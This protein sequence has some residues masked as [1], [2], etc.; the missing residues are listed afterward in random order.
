MKLKNLPILFALV[1]PAIAQQAAVV[2]VDDAPG[3]YT[4]TMPAEPAWRAYV[5]GQSVVRMTVQV[6]AGAAACKLGFTWMGLGEKEAMYIHAAGEVAHGPYVGYGPLNRPDFDSQWLPGNEFAVTA[7]GKPT[8]DFPFVLRSVSCK[9]AEELAAEPVKLSRSYTPSKGPAAGDQVTAMVDDTMVIAE[10]R[11]GKVM[12]QDDIILP[13]DMPV[14]GK[15]PNREAMQAAAN[16]AWPKFRVPYAIAMPEW[17]GEFPNFRINDV[18]RGIA[19]WNSLFPGLLVEATSADKD[20]VKI[21]TANGVC[22]SSVGRVGGAQT[23]GLAD[24]CSDA[25]ILHEFAHAIGMWHEQSRQDRDEYVKINWNKIRDGKAHNFAMV[26]ISNGTDYG[27]YDYTSLM[28]Y[29]ATAFSTDGSATIERL[30]PMP[31]GGATMGGATA[32]S[33]GDISAVRN[34]IC[35]VWYNAPAAMTLDG[36]G[37]EVAVNIVLPNYCAWTVTETA[38]WLSFNKTTGTGPAT[39]LMKAGFNMINGKRQTTVRINGKAMNVTQNK[40]E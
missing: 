16:R 28:H 7:T 40:F 5:N 32:A 38:T 15:N 9:T 13:E 11:D 23:I 34:M 22:E 20:Y 36:E 24:S 1:T 4:V 39:I 31:A 35:R 6:P 25:A 27:T 8:A 26:G 37:D 29:S 33:A 30:L 21:V 17:D 10:R 12:L 3:S 2:P 19:Y 18:K 14:A